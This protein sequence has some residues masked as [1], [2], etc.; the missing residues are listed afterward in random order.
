[1]IMVE[2]VRKRAVRKDK[3]VAAPEKRRSPE[4]YARMRAGMHRV[5]RTKMILRV[6]AEAPALLPEQVEEIRAAVDRIQV[7]GAVQVE[8]AGA[9]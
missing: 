5:K 9:A 7:V 6:M 3:G 1:M 2:Q 4:H 8:V